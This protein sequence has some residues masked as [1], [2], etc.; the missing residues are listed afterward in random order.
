MV[1]DF[2]LHDTGEGNP[3]AHIMLTTREVGADGF[4]KKNRDW[5][6]KSLL[7]SWRKNWANICNEKFREKG[8]R[9]RID[10]RTLEAQGIDREPTIHLNNFKSYT[11]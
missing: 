6:S 3:H 5:N 8:L 7:I 2:A 10:E 9:A 4:G 1:A 11:F